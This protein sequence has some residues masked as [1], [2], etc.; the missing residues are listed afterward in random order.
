MN[1]CILGNTYIVQKYDEQKLVDYQKNKVIVEFNNLQ[2][3]TC[4]LLK[5]CKLTFTI[6]VLS[7]PTIC[8]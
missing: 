8:L 4:C 7:I 6:K 3:K 2:F 5:V 1:V